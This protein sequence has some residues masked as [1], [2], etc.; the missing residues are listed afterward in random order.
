MSEP[1]DPYI[2][3]RIAIT[4][5]MHRIPD[6][7]PLPPLPAISPPPVM[8][9]ECPVCGKKFEP[10]NAQKFCSPDCRISEEHRRRHVA[11][12][13]ADGQRKDKE[14]RALQAAISA[15][16]TVW[17]ITP[18]ELTTPREHRR[19]RMVLA[20]YTMTAISREMLVPRRAIAQSLDSTEQ[21]VRHW[22]GMGRYKLAHPNVG[23]G[24]KEFAR[25]YADALAMVRA[26][27]EKQE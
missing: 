4:R 13:A 11:R 9:S 2:R 23:Q 18:E 26:A 12:A 16:A 8:R 22:G 27:L 17:Q 6:D 7:T 5:R 20:R 10:S 14:K 15:A 21:C 19:H 24:N 25:R 1:L 3:E